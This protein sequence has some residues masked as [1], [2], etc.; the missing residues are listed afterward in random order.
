[1]KMIRS[2]VANAEIIIIFIHLHIVRIREVRN[3][4]NVIK[5]EKCLFC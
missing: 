3:V 1:M 2:A 5:E 4:K